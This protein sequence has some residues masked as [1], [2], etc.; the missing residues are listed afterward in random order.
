MIR[1]CH[2]FISPGHNFAGHHDQPPGEHPLIEVDS[3]ECVAGR[4]L[5]GDRYFDHK[6][7]YKGQITFFA[8]EVFDA[9]RRELNLSAAQPQATRRNVFTR[10]ADLN[11]L[12]G[13]EFEIQGV[14]FAGV[15]E[16]SP[17]YWMNRVLGAGAENFLQDRGGLRARILA[18]GVLRRDV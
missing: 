10:G 12:V 11:T 3:V 9:L 6:Q 2:I 15:A 4:G 18:D 13:K 14:R 1:V 16:C 7:D 5:R 17:C 8:L